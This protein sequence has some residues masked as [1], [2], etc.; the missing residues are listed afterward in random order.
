[1][2]LAL[3]GLLAGALTTISFIPQVYK[4]WKTKSAKD[5]SLG[6]Y[7][8]MVTGIVLW[9]LYGV[10]TADFPII[11]ANLCTLLLAGMLLYFK[12]RYT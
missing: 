10:L 7:L 8:V 5:L 6:M 3:L 12:L 1:M 9:L 2:E 4:T 11:A